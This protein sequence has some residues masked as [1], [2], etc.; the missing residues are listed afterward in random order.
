MCEHLS[1]RPLNVIAAGGPMGGPWPRLPT[2]AAP[3]NFDR[4]VCGTRVR[5]PETALKPSRGPRL[6]I[7]IHSATGHFVL[8]A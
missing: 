5:E 7:C 1:L 2:T 4:N 6:Q 8:N 3:R